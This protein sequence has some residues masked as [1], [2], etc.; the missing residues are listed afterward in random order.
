MI[1]L[2]MNSLAGRL[3]LNVRKHADTRVVKKVTCDDFS[4]ARFLG[5]HSVFGDA[6]SPQDPA[7]HLLTMHKNSVEL[8]APIVVGV[9]VLE[10]SKTHMLRLWYAGLRSAWADARL[11]YS[12]T[13]SFYFAVPGAHDEALCKLKRISCVDAA[14]TKIPGLLKIECER[15]TEFISFGKKSYSALLHHGDQKAGLSGFRNTPEHEVFKLRL[16]D[17]DVEV[18]AVQKRL[19]RDRETCET[20]V[21]RNHE[22]RRLGR[23]VE[24]SR[25]WF[26]G[27]CTS[28]A[29]GHHKNRKE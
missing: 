17:I 27:R 23:S 14:R 22:T 4:S 13:D 9:C 21:I 18:G 28:R 8:K 10:K 25:Y 19:G 24:A 12:D 29:I 7:L 2:I 16:S 1:K 11:L 6:N 15:V 20:T 5:M 3:Q 26:P